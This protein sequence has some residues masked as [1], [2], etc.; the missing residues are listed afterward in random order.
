[1]R[2]HRLGR[3]A[4]EPR[5]WPATVP[6]GPDRKPT[7]AAPRWNLQERRVDRNS[8]PGRAA[9]RR[10][11]ACRP[12]R[13]GPATPRR[14]PTPEPAAPVGSLL[15]LQRSFVRWGRAGFGVVERVFGRDGAAGAAQVT[16]SR[17]AGLDPSRVDQ[18]PQQ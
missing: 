17:L 14:A 4:D 18:V 13:P 11:G 5:A 7:R 16:R 2:L 8:S 12:R 9:E 15:R 3:L 10:A 1:H 6:P